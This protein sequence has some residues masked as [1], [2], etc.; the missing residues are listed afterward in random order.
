MVIMKNLRRIGGGLLRKNKYKKEYRLKRLVLIFFLSLVCVQ[1]SFGQVRRNNSE[2]NKLSLEL[3][4][5]FDFPFQPRHFLPDGEKASVSDYKA[6]GGQV[7]ARYMFNSFVG[8]RAHYGF[9]HFF[10]TVPRVGTFLRFHRYAGEIVLSGADLFEPR[11]FHNPR[12]WNVLVHGG[13]GLT[14]GF[15]SDL[16][17][18]K[19]KE[20]YK[21]YIHENIY[22]YMIGFTP[23][24]KL[25]NRFSAYAAF[26]L[27]FS[28]KQNFGYHG[29]FL[30]ESVPKAQL[31]IFM[32]SSLGITYSIGSRNDHIDWR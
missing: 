15:P 30:P 22:S 31:G 10:T 19:E 25:N 20:G 27:H 24:Y 2:F 17:N 1:M 29:R 26:N 13:M 8:I 18:K 32:N 3:Q 7:G 4:G 5:G 16:R 6:Y 14:H 21:G 28:R 11:H 12:K 23:Q 9:H